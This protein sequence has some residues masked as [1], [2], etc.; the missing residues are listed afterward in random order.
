MKNILIIISA[1]IIL[2][3]IFKMYKKEKYELKSIHTKN[4]L[5]LSFGP[6]NFPGD[7]F[8]FNENNPIS[9]TLDYNIATDLTFEKD[10]M[11]KQM[12]LP[13]YPIQ[14]LQI[15]KKK[16]ITIVSNIDAQPTNVTQPNGIKIFYTDIFLFNANYTVPMAS[17]FINQS[18][19]LCAFFSSTQE[20]IACFNDPIDPQDR[21]IFFNPINN[22]SSLNVIPTIIKPNFVY[23]APFPF[24]FNGKLNF[25]LPNFYINGLLL[26]YVEDSKFDGKGIFYDLVSIPAILSTNQ[27]NYLYTK[28]IFA[29][30]ERIFISPGD[31]PFNY[32]A[33][34]PFYVPNNNS[35]YDPKTEIFNPIAPL[36][37][38]YLNNKEFFSC[39][40]P[41]DFPNCAYTLF[42]QPNGIFYSLFFIDYNGHLYCACSPDIND[43][44]DYRIQ[45]KPYDST[46]SDKTLLLWL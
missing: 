36:N 34:I 41:N 33:Y 19:Q 39:Y 6:G 45:W 31:N 2:C 43:S 11:G 9:L 44:H 22:P 32:F 42:L 1:F 40:A 46:N 28:I 26:Q 20:Y 16:Y 3:V 37:G 25:P 29:D 17:L 27:P 5:V 7:R 4:A 13:S 30:G 14:K 21:G 35:F 23:I 18:N 15:N 38:I 12:N 10:D 8:V 24:Q